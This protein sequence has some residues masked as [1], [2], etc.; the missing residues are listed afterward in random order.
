[1]LSLLK[2][3]KLIKPGSVTTNQNANTG[4]AN[5]GS[6]NTGSANTGSANTGS[7]TKP[8]NTG[9]GAT[10]LNSKADLS[11]KNK[12]K[13]NG[14]KYISYKG[15]RSAAALNTVIDQYFVE[16]NSRYA[17]T[18]K[19]TYCNIF[20]SD[21]MLAMGLEGDYSHWLKNNVPV[22]ST[23]KDAYELN[24]N[25]TYD[26]INNYGHKHGW[27]QITAQEAQQR[28]NAGYPTIA[29]WR[30]V[31][32]KPGHVAVVRPEGNGYY[33]SA[34]K[35]PVIAQAGGSN[36]SYGNLTRGFGS[37]KLSTTQFWTH[38]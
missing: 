14:I 8:T 2:S 13:E 30:N 5:T 33:Y 32:G 25:A 1:M 6:A 34:S 15:Q 35:G 38:D 19:S 12:A 29:I 23:T 11:V 21:V 7:Q 27:R 26:W 18:S 36:F 31:N 10:L 9:K 22:H 24:A 16:T 37:N 28:A 4:S 20:A 17:K 3:G